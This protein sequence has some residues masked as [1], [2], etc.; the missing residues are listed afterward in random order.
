MIGKPALKNDPIMDMVKH[1]MITMGQLYCI[2]YH[3]YWHSLE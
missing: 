3:G 1:E 2:G